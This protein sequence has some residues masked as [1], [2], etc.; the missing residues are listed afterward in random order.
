M[1]FIEDGDVLCRWPCSQRYDLESG[2]KT[3]AL[4]ITLASRE[5]CTRRRRRVGTRGGRC[6]NRE[7]RPGTGFARRDFRPDSIFRFAPA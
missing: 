1:I 6:K 3:A 2:G 5:A 4:H 7:E